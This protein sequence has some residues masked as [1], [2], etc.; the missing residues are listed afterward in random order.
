VVTVASWPEILS[1]ETTLN[2]D[3][4]VTQI[5]ERTINTGE[6]EVGDHACGKVKGAWLEFLC[7]L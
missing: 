6:L 5:F 7:E 3:A 4:G 1:T 2:L